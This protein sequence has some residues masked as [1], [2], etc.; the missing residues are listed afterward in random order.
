MCLGEK[1][2]PL[3]FSSPSVIRSHSWHKYRPFCNL[4][5][6]SILPSDADQVDNLRDGASKHGLQP[7]KGWVRKGGVGKMHAWVVVVTWDANRRVHSQMPDKQKLY[8]FPLVPW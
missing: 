4:E 6:A 7:G 1:H 5:G 3:L 8:L 2:E